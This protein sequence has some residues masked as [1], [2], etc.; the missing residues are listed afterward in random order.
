ML[1]VRRLISIETEE[2]NSHNSLR[3]GNELKIVKP[4]INL[5]LL[6]MLLEMYIFRNYFALYAFFFILKASQ[7]FQ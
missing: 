1:S 4:E 2:R 3:D 5:N 7:T 6:T